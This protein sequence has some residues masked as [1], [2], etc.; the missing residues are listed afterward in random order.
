LKK[1]LKKLVKSEE[2]LKEYSSG[3]E[4][5]LFMTSHKLRQ[6]VAHILGIS[7]LLDHSIKF[8][9]L[10]IMVNYL[11]HSALSLDG[12]TFELT[13]LIVSLEKKAKFSA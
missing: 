8:S 3:L 1:D 10:K 11:K 12:F 5:M 13:N 7:N 6:P 2:F 9:E 4:K